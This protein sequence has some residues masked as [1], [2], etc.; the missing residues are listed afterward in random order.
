MRLPDSAS[1][2][3]VLLVVGPGRSGTSAVA[4]SLA[5]SGFH[6]P[7]P[8]GA[9]ESNP[10]GFYEPRWL[11]DFD[12]ARLRAARVGTL[13]PD[14]GAYELF[15][16]VTDWD[17]AK[18][19]LLPWLET[20]LATEDRL[21][22]KDP[23]LIW[24]Y[25]LWADLAAELDFDLGFLMMMRHPSEVSASRSTRNET[26]VPAR[27]V[28]GW[29]NVALM[30]ERLT[31]G[32]RRAVIHYPDLVSDWRRELSR[33]E[34]LLDVRLEPGADQRPHPVDDFLDPSLRRESPGWDGLSVPGWLR[35]L[36]DRSFE[37][38]NTIA[39]SGTPVPTATLDA[40]AQEYAELYEAAASIAH[41]RPRRS[42]GGDA[43][44]AEPP[45]DAT[46]A[47][48]VERRR[49]RSLLQRR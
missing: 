16:Q 7:N 15:Q 23:R 30:T 29:I 6:V 40:F 12:K 31:R 39:G 47:A 48:P 46:P 26:I 1:S 24:F 21:V 2:R 44:P 45:A 10:R 18:A 38:L 49:F 22:L 35:D 8:I 3:Q 20:Q 33:V 17:V 14:P 28:A 9:H 5:R 36:A 42:K 43:A 11:V 27:A 4:G 34:G 37:A 32:G 19:E 41:A 25:P 13:D